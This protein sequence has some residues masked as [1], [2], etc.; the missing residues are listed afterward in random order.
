MMTE[1]LRCPGL[2][3]SLLLL[4]LSSRSLSFIPPFP[5]D[6][7]EKLRQ[8]S[9]FG[10]HIVPYVSYSLL[11][12]HICSLRPY[13]SWSTKGLLSQCPSRHKSLLRVLLEEVA[14][15]GNERTRFP[16]AVT[17]PATQPYRGQRI[18]V[19]TVASISPTPSGDSVL[20]QRLLS[21]TADSLLPVST[22][23]AAPRHVE[24]KTL[25]ILPL[26]GKFSAFLPSLTV[27]GFGANSHCSEPTQ[28]C[29]TA[30]LNFPEGRQVSYIACGAVAVTERLL[31]L[32]TA[33]L[34]VT[35]GATIISSNKPTPTPTQSPATCAPGAAS[36]CP[37]GSTCIKS[38]TS[39]PG[40]SSP[41]ATTTPPVSLPSDSAQATTTGSIGVII[42]GVVGGLALVCISVVVAIYLTRRDRAEKRRKTMKPL[43]TP[44]HERRGDSMSCNDGNYKYSGGWGPAE[45][46]GNRPSSWMPRGP[47]ELPG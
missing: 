20:R 25:V 8:P 40:T 17:S 35:E 31:F 43:V 14:I 23:T 42:G 37:K 26:R 16:H 18:Q 2:L 44:M 27:V 47:V 1:P 28:F 4:D 11:T 34:T 15:L 13:S 9:L 46:E 41:L 7:V 36:C 21:L 5:A 6:L 38:Q 24:S 39:E 29:S 22:S 33:A 32:P 3:G 30:L 10:L 19:S 12:I 45:L